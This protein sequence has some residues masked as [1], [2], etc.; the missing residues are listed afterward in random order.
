M[1]ILATTANYQE[2]TDYYTKSGDTYTLLVAGTDYTIGDTITGTKYEGVKYD[3]L[4][5]RTWGS[6]GA[7]QQF[8]YEIGGVRT[9][10]PHDSSAN[11]VDLDAYTNTKG[12]TIRGRVRSNVAA[13]D[14]KVPTM[15]GAE[16]QDFFTMTSPEWL[17]CY[18]FYEPSWSFVSKKMYRSGTVKYTKYYVDNTSPNN[19]IYNDV[20]F[21]FVE[22]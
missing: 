17:D 14:F 11:D 9:L 12:K 1:Y 5:I 18:F 3:R 19:N 20:S 16:L 21:G 13:L 8:P 4:Y 2:G 15:S 6:T 22:Q 7:Y 10:P